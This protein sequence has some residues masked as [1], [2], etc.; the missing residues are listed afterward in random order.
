[1]FYFSNS[2]CQLICIIIIH[3]RI[4]NLHL[5]II[6]EIVGMSEITEKDCSG[7]MSKLLDIQLRDLRLVIACITIMITWM[8]NSESNDALRVSQ[9]MTPDLS[10][11]VKDSFPLSCWKSIDQTTTSSE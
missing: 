6:G 4:G 2:P 11:K 8:P 7:T 3:N 9:L 1:M 5:N 10:Q